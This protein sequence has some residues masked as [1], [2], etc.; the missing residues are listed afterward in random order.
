MRARPLS[1]QPVGAD[2]GPGQAVG[3][4]ELAGHFGRLG[5]NAAGGYGVA[6]LVQRGAQLQ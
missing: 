5:E 1:A 4:A 6:G 2:G 3:V